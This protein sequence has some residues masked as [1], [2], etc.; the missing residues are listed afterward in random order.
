MPYNNCE[1]T[2]TL[3]ALHVSAGLCRYALPLI[4]SHLS[5]CRAVQNFDQFAK[6]FNCPANSP[7]NPP[8]K[9]VL[10]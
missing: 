6:T 5:T 8:N 7:M 9:C 2:R 1:T 10:W 4:L 3:P